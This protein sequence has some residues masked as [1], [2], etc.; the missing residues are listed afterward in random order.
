MAEASWR[1]T[2]EPLNF[3]ESQSTSRAYDYA[4]QDQAF[5]IGQDLVTAK[6]AHKQAMMNDPLSA[7]GSRD[8]IRAMQQYLAAYR[9]GV[10]LPDQVVLPPMRMTS[11]SEQSSSSRGGGV[12]AMAQSKDFIDRV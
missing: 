6:G 11:N 8:R 9:A 5:K 3:S 10:D 4:G 1:V 2:Q 12:G 7:V